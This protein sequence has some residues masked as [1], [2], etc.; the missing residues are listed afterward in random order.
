MTE[1]TQQVRETTTRTGNTLQKNT[2]VSNPR[3]ETGHWQNVAAR[4]VWYVAGILLVLLA[5]RFALSLLGANTNNGFANFIYTTSH[6]FVT[7]FFSLFS[8]NTQINGV[9][10]FEIYTLVAMIF[11]AVLAWGI[12]KLVTLNRS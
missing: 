9:S 10:H 1:D 5:S 12:A 7:P 3:N 8:Y 4:V 2:E 6:P 11:Y